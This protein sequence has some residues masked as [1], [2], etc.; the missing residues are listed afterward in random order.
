[1]TKLRTVRFLAVEKITFLY[2]ALTLVII[3]HFSPQLQN[4]HEL[5]LNRFFIIAVILGLAFLNFLKDWWVIRFARFAFLGGLLAYWYPETF[6]INRIIVNYD[7][8]IAGL[9]QSIF[10]F[11][12]ALVFSQHFPQLWFSEILNMGYFAYYPLIIGTCIYF[13][14]KDK[15]YFEFFFFSILFSFFCY[16]LIFILFP[17]AGPQYYYQ[18]IGTDQVHSGVF[19]Q[20]GLYFNEHQSLINTADSRGFFA[21]M[22]QNTQQVGERPTAAFPSSHVG[23]STLIMILVFQ[24]RQ[25]KL[26]AFLFPI[27]LALVFATVYIQ[28]HYVIDVLVGFVSSF[29][30]FF[31]GSLVYKP[32]T[33]RL[34]GIPRL[35]SILLK[36]PIDVGEFK[37]L[38]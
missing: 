27:Y 11:Q 24:K 18:A 14:V 35:V 29:T 28:A 16:Y 9:E 31:L 12:P 5:V 17:T 36:K 37:G 32:F 19:Q 30:F 26:S 10:G 15:K 34:F 22:V 21:Q 8:L 38:N 23:I 3:N 25:F 33:Y 13:Y 20:I 7:Y 2:I 1:M 4:A 6:D